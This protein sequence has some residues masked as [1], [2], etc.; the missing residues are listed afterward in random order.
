MTLDAL[1]YLTITIII[2]TF[3]IIII[4]SVIIIIYSL[5]IIITQLLG[6][7]CAIY[8]YITLYICVCST[9]ST[10]IN[11]LSTLKI[12]KISAY[13]VPSFRA[14]CDIG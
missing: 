13:S 7:I 3:S 6:S 10:R 14:R 9:L 8:S 11:A 2:I 5:I 1:L 12:A 4:T